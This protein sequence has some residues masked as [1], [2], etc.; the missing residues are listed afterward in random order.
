MHE[1]GEIPLFQLDAPDG[2]RRGTLDAWQRREMLV[3]LLHPGCDVC[4]ALHRS[5]VDRTPELHRDEVDVFAVVR[6]G[7]PEAPVPPGALVDAEG[8]VTRTLSEALHL[9][10]DAAVLAVANRFSKLYAVVDLHSGPTAAVLKEAM[11][12]LQLAQLQCGECQA[13]L[14]WD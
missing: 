1:R 2:R 5:L 3:A 9:A 6:P 12:W 14:D 10:P 7:A 4:Q 11:E 13:P 8:R